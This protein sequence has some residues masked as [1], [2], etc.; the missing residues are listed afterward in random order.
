MA[1][2]A[3]PIAWHAYPRSCALIPMRWRFRTT[4]PKATWPPLA[5]GKLGTHINVTPALIA[6]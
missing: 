1:I 6:A 2:F 4:V 3:G 5:L